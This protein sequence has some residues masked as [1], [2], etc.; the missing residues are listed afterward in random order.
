MCTAATTQRPSMARATE[1]GD[2]HNV[3]VEHPHRRGYIEWKGVQVMTT[4]S[5]R[6]ALR[7]AALFCLFTMAGCQSSDRIAPDGSTISL[8]ATPSSILLAGGVQAGSVT[9]LAT[10]DNTLG[11]PLPGQDVRFTTTSG[12]LTPQ[13]GTPVRSN[14]DGNAITVLTGATQNTTITAK[15]GKVSQTLQLSTTT[16]TIGSIVISPTTVTLNDCSTSIDVTANVADTNGDPCVGV[17][18]TFATVP[19]TPATDVVVTFTPPAPKTDANG[20]ATTSLTPQST[21]CNTK[22]FGGSNICTGSF[23]ASAGGV[24]S[25]PATRIIDGT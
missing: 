13:G 16:C 24:K 5:Y 3:V 10:V 4:R 8:N 6:P 20:D 2:K 17:L 18:V 15:S 22:C 11:V 7:T 21:D 19:V 14:Q 12:V 23:A 9:I 25:T 1:T